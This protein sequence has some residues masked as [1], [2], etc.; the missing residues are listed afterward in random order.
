[1]SIRNKTLSFNRNNILSLYGFNAN[2]PTPFLPYCDEN[3][4]TLVLDSDESLVHFFYC[5]S[6]GTFLIRPYFYKFL[7]EMSAI[8]EIAIFTAAMQDYVD[9]II[10]FLNFFQNLIIHQFH[11]FVFHLNYYTYI[12]LY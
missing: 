11:I 3:T 10:D 9:G 5:S 6:G 8:F 1:M 7:R 4:Y 12:K 2:I